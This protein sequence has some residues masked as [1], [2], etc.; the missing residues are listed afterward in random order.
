MSDRSI[1]VLRTFF[2]FLLLSGRESISIERTRKERF[3]HALRTVSK[4]AFSQLG[5]GRC[6]TLIFLAFGT[7]IRDCE[8]RSFFLLFSRRL[9][10]NTFPS[11]PAQ[12][13]FPFLARRKINVAVNAYRTDVIMTMTLLHYFP[14]L[15]F[16]HSTRSVMEQPESHSRL[17]LMN[18]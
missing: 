16:L 17:V 7:S 3:R 2:D 1:C 10:L 4:V 6:I 5:L 9:S 12:E 8:E 15:C 18:I 13:G 11:P 14:V